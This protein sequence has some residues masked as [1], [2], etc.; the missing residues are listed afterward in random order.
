M[1]LAKGKHGQRQTSQQRRNDIQRLVESL[2]ALEDYER[3]GIQYFVCWNYQPCR[4]DPRNA[5]AHV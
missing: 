4:K 5:H 3:S 1:E 2:E